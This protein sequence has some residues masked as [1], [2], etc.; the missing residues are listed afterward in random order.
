MMSDSQDP[1]QEQNRNA[2]LY[3]R[4][5]VTVNHRSSAISPK[6][7]FITTYATANMANDRFNYYDNNGNNNSNDVVTVFDN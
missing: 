2:V 4:P 5:L 7:Q 3:S 6:K 1:Q